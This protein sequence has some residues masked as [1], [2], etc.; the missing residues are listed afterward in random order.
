MWPGKPKLFTIWPFPQQVCGPRP[1]Y[2]FCYIN[3][4][5][6]KGLWRASGEHVRHMLLVTGSSVF[7]SI[8]IE[9]L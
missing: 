7:L 8:I 6:T 4:G 3:G 9:L 1:K 5:P 2:H